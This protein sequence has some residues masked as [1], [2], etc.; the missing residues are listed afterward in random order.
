MQQRTLLA[1]FAMLFLV[2]ASG[3]RLKAED[4]QPQPSPV[5]VELFTSQGCSSCP[6]ADKLLIGLA[7]IG[8]KHQLPVYCLSFHVDYWNSL[9]WRDP[10]SSEQFTKRQRQYAA[11]FQSNR[12]YTPQMIVGGE[13]EFVGSRGRDAQQAIQSALAAPATS[14]VTL[15]TSVSADRRTVS[16][17]YA[18]HDSAP[19]EKLNIALVQ[20]SAS[21]EVPRG[22][23]SGRSLAHVHVVRVFRTIDLQKPTGVLDLDLPEGL[24]AEASSVV[25]YVQ[26]QRSL[27]ITGA[28]SSLVVADSVR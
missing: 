12:V 7:E 13:I 25:A 17:S 20:N 22:E 24:S 10:Y 26:D 16:V 4:C 9:G 27:R 3:N 21:N 15:E 2:S 11:A 8:E 28:A 6:P 18:V 23:N 1:T 5:V 14:T 19:A